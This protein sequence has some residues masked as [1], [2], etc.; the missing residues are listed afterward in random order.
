MIER[1]INL[2]ANL[3][4]VH[5]IKKIHDEHISSIIETES[6]HQ[7]NQMV[8]LLNIGIESLLKRD[9]VFVFIKDTTFRPPPRPTV[10]L[11]EEIDGETETA[12]APARSLDFEGKQYLIVGEEVLDPESEYEEKHAFFGSGFVLFPDRR[13]GPKKPAYFMI[14]PIDFIELEE[15]KDELGIENIMSTSPSNITDDYLREAFGFPTDPDLATIL[16]GFDRA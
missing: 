6:I 5:G 1:V 7:K 2:I 13:K 11:V 8:Q 3:P 15:I 10:Y 16:V 9:L 4:G 12:E 14:P